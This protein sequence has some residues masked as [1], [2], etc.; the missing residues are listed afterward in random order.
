MDFKLINSDEQLTGLRNH[1]FSKN[2]AKI[3][4]DF[5]GDFGTY[6][7]GNKLCLI[8][9]YDGKEFYIID[10]FKISK[11]EMIKFFAEKRIIKYMYG[12]GSDIKLIYDQYKIKVQSI[13]DLQILIDVL[14]ISP[15]SLDAVIKNV[16]NISLD[17]DKKKFQM[18]NWARRPLPKEVTEYALSDV[19]YLFALHD[20]LW[21]RITAENLTE[22]LIEKL[23]KADYDF[24]LRDNI[25]ALFKSKP[26][27]ALPGN[28][29]SLFKKIYD[30]REETGRKYD[31]P[32]SQIISKEDLFKLAADT[33]LINTFGFNRR[34]TGNIK[35]E[36][37]NKINSL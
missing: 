22:T 9:I 12:A 17:F 8:Q 14:D 24:E 18:Y 34:I 26:Y 28:K 23:I 25:P 11:D 2:I 19:K 33:H 10:P 21:N 31:I 3:A 30:I 36:I 32:S 13:Y 7:Y 4:M 37:L 29:K 1:F 35:N 27:L 5:E 15:K 16:L 20:T 6:S